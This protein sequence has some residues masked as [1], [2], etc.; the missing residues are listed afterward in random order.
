MWKMEDMLLK[1][2]IDQYLP[3]S[4]EVEGSR[5]GVLVRMR[6]EKIGSRRLPLTPQDIIEHAEWRG[7]TVQGS[8]I[9]GDI[10]ALRGMLDYAEVG[11]GIKGVSSEPIR[12]AIPVLKRKRLVGSS[13]TRDRIPLPEEHAAIIAHLRATNTR[14]VV[15][16]TIDYQYHSGRRISEACRHEW[17]QFDAESKTILILNLK[18]PR[19]KTGHNLRAAV[20]DEACE[21]ILRQPRET[22]DPKERIFKT[23]TG[24]VKGAYGRAKK[25]CKIEGLHLHDSRGGVVTRLLEDGYTPAEVQLVT[26]NSLNM[27][28][29]RYNRMRPED[30]PRRAK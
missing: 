7:R 17:G 10:S 18:H 25:A 20:T 9:A 3:K 15:I 28:N 5:R 14:P 21:I 8:T 1:Q 23:C 24:T 12:S 19:K 6:Q 13:N 26:V 27:I 22:S 30:F 11:L 16:E 4:P 29:T 2:L